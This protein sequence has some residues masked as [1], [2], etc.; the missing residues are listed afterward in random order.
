MRM[1]RCLFVRIA[2]RVIAA[3]VLLVATQARA[4][5]TAYEWVTQGGPNNLIDSNP[6][7][8]YPGQ[9]C[10][11]RSGR[12]CSASPSQICDLQIVPVNRCTSG[13]L[14]PDGGPGL[15]NTCVWPHGAGHCAGNAH[16]GCLTDAYLVNPAVTASGAERH[17]RRNGQL[18]LRHVGRPVRRTVSERLRLQ[19]QRRERR[20]LRDGGLPWRSAA[21]LRRR[22]TAR[23]RRLRSGLR[24][25]AQSRLRQPHLGE[26]GA[27]R[28]R[29]RSSVDLAALSDREP[30]SQFEAQ[31]EPGTVGRL[32]FAGGAITP[33]AR[34]RRA[35]A[36][37]SIRVWGPRCCRGS[38]TRTLGRL[39]LR[40]P[41]HHGLLQHAHGAAQLQRAGGLG[42]CRRSIRPPARRAAATRPTAARP[43]ATRSQSTGSAISRRSSSRR[44]RSARRLAARTST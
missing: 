10:Y 12:P 8:C 31:R 34:Q 18:H 22:P 9:D 24:L 28:E 13:W 15:T 33:C 4:D 44:I 21:L 41:A 20:E 42:H 2:H 39:D 37:R 19:R 26:A 36:P 30:P 35:S 40:D 29:K 32:A 27:G 14:A 6:S 25:R 43:D 1:S 5:V 38:V 11:D 3:L 16:V 7:S 23:S 17:V